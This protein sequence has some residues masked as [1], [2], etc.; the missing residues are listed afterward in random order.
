M[1]KMQMI[2]IRAAAE[3]TQPPRFCHPERSEG[4]HGRNPLYIVGFFANAQND[5][6]RG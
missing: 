6:Y 3:S 1:I 2:Y 4:S 5:S